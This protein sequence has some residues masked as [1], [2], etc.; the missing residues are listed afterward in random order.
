MK[1]YTTDKIRNVVLAGHSGSGKT[2][3]AES[4]AYLAHQTTRMGSIDSGTTVSDF[5]PQETKRKMSIRTSVL[6]IPWDDCKINLLDA[7]GSFDFT[8]ETAEAFSAADACVIVVSGKNGIEA[9]TKRAFDLCDKYHLPREV[10]VTD[11]DD[12]DA[13]FR[14]VVEDLTAL[15][16]KKIAPFHLPIR[17]D[18]KFVGYINVITKSAMRWTKSGEVV[19][20]EVPEYS[21]Q[22]LSICSTAL[23]EAVAESSE[24]FLNRYFEGDSFSEDEIRQALRVNVQEG[25]II[26]VSMGSSILSQGVF[27]L[28]DDILKYFPSPD[29]R[30]CVGIDAVSNEVYPANYD[31]SKPKS[32]YIFKTLVDPKLGTY[33]FFKVNSGVIKTDDVLYNQHR[34]IET[35]I[36]KLYCVFGKKFTEVAELHAGDIGAVSRLSGANTTDSLSTRQHPILYIRTDIPVPYACARYAAKNKGDEDRAASALA[37]IGKEFLTVQTKVDSVCHQTLLYGISGR[38]LE[39]VADK[40]ES[41]Y[42]TE[43]ELLPLKI[44]YQETISG[45]SDVEYKYKK[46]SGGHGQYGHVKMRFSPSGQPDEPYQFVESVVGGAVPKNYFPAV[47]KGIAEGVKCGPLAGY[48]VTGIKAELYDGSYHPVDS[49]E[50]AFKTASLFAFREGIMKAGPLLLEPI[51]L[52]RITVSESATGDILGD[53][54]KRRAHVTGM[55]AVE[56]NG[57]LQVITAEIPYEQLY[58]YDRVLRSASGGNCDYSYRFLCYRKAPDAV[59]EREIESREKRIGKES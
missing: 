33:S 29:R 24:E 6:S 22:N 42:K 23:I 12:D 39:I 55:D 34:D 37:K 32:A 3:L 30:E 45:T 44:A 21:R 31:F 9:G 51:A 40:A 13:S 41:D 4:M 46:Q 53:L 36:G 8:G 20:A 43:I 38:Q 56:G 15:Y 49:S 18:K 16:G 27:T 54:N 25:S 50:Q 19:P 58:E 11:M 35:K 57:N 14:Q 5:D 48:P 28:L 10:F 59:A 47:E 17:E 7:P 1:I 26:P 2:S 52:L